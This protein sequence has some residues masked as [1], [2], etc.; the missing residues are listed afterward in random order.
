M[1]RSTSISKKR[2]K[3]CYRWVNAFIALIISLS[4]NKTAVNLSI[5]DDGIGFNTHIKSKGIGL[6]NIRSRAISFG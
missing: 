3:K 2:D 5:A 6:E 1:Q 4:Q